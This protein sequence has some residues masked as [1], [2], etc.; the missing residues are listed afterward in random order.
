MVFVQDM[1]CMVPG[2]A[3]PHLLSQVNEMDTTVSSPYVDSASV[4][5]QLA[6]INRLISISYQEQEWFMSFE[7]LIR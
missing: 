4:F 3:R 2:I 6:L 7:L 1:V 5:E